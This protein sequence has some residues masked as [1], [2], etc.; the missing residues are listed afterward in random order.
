MRKRRK[1]EAHTHHPPVLHTDAASLGEPVD[2]SRPAVR[3]WQQAERA[4]RRGDLPRAKLFAFHAMEIGQ[5]S[6]MGDQAA[7]AAASQV[8]LNVALSTEDF[9]GI[10][11]VANIARQLFLRLHLRLHAADVDRI[12]AEA[13]WRLAD[14][15]GANQLIMRARKT[16]A[17]AKDHIGVATC[18]MQRARMMATVSPP[19]SEATKL[20]CSARAVFLRASQLVLAAQCDVALSKYEQAAGKF[21]E[22]ETLLSRALDTFAAHDMAVDAARAVR[23]RRSI[24]GPRQ[25]RRSNRD[26]PVGAGRAGRRRAISGGG[27][28]R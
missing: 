16:F 5:E 10:R 28:L 3:S 6:D 27:E 17:A 8:L 9:E 14:A 11:A 4:F 18:D 22:A 21:D 7:A 25:R 13:C 20:L 24:R 1:R 23:A 12:E 19:P 2:S 26:S 15:P